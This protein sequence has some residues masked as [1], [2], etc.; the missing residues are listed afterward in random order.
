MA[1]SADHREAILEMKYKMKR[2]VEKFRTQ[3]TGVVGTFGYMAPEYANG[4]RASKES[5]M[6]SFG[7]VALELA[8]G[9]R[10]YQEGE[11][12]V[13]LF[14]KERPKAGHVMKV[15]QLEAPLPVLPYDMHRYDHLMPQDNDLSPSAR[16]TIA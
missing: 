7:V 12:D 2:L 9:R 4:G 10:T 16:C 1:F 15:L 5:D 11:Y 3:T 6:F 14:S 8:C 13:P